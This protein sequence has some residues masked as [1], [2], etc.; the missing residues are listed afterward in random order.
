[1]TTVAVTLVAL[2]LVFL[3]L[4]VVRPHYLPPAVQVVDGAHMTQ[5]T[6]LRDGRNRTMRSG[7]NWTYRRTAFRAC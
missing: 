5:P 3:G 7:G 2:P 6:R 4:V 1:M